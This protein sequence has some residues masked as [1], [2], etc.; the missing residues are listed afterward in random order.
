MTL[1]TAILLLFV[2]VVAIVLTIHCLKNRVKLR[3]ICLVLL[4]LAALL[5]VIYI[6]LTWILIASID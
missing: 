1:W 3:N 6:L 2:T 5:L 4:S